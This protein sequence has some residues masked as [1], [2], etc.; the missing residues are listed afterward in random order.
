VTMNK[1]QPQ[2]AHPSSS[3]AGS[4]SEAPSDI[5]LMQYF[6]DELEEPRRSAVAAFVG[7]DPRARNKLAAMSITSAVVRNEAESL[8]P[9]RRSPSSSHTAESI[10]DLV[11]AKIAA[12]SP[13]QAAPVYPPAQ[14]IAF[15]AREAAPGQAAPGQAAPGQAVLAPRQARPAA[16]DNGRRILGAIAALAVAAAAGLAIW[17][18]L[19]TESTAPSRNMPIA[20]HTSPS[21]QPSLRSTEPELD[22]AAVTAEADT[23]HGVDVAAVNF[24]ARTGSIFFV[25]SGSIEAKRT[26]TVVWLADDAGE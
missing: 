9:H 14:V 8:F 18:R 26:T 12:S 22:A 16:N 4:L 24:G 5:E 3:K 11:M 17:S 10:A 13:P 25:P 19:G 7:A 21:T 6:D 20:S 23:E 2:P 1:E 15:P